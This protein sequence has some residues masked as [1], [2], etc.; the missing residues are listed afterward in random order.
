MRSRQGRSLPQCVLQSCWQPQDTAERIK[1]Q[2]RRRGWK[3]METR[4]RQGREGLAGG[5]VLSREQEGGGYGGCRG[6]GG[7]SLRTH[8]QKPEAAV[9]LRS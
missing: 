2:R 5:Q 7:Q 3:G 8:L 6:A 1:Q 9:G 4:C